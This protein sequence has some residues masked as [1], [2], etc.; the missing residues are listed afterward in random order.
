M[1]HKQF[2]NGK[3]KEKDFRIGRNKTKTL[4]VE[5]KTNQRDFI[6]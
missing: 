5:G 6:N 2:K 4:K 1:D 3:K